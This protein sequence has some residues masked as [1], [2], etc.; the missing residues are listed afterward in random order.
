MSEPVIV[1]PPKT[2]SINRK[3]QRPPVYQQQPRKQ[4]SNV[5]ET[6]NVV[7]PS[8]TSDTPSII[9]NTPDF[10]PGSMVGNHFDTHGFNP[11]S[12]IPELFETNEDDNDESYQIF[13]P[14]PSSSS[15]TYYND[16]ISVPTDF[17][18]LNDFLRF[19]KENRPPPMQIQELLDFIPPDEADYPQIELPNVLTS[20]ISKVYRETKDS[21]IAQNKD[22]QTEISLR[23]KSFKQK[24]PEL[25]DRISLLTDDQKSIVIQN[26]I[27]HYKHICLDSQ[28]TVLNKIY[29]LFQKIQKNCQ[30]IQQLSSQQQKITKFLTKDPK[31]QKA[32][33][34]IDLQNQIEQN[35]QAIELLEHNEAKYKILKIFLSFDVT[36]II[37][38]TATVEIFGK[39]KPFQAMD[40]I[41]VHAKAA[42]IQRQKE[43]QVELR[44]ISQLIPFVIH[45]NNVVSVTFVKYDID[46]RFEV[47][48]KI[49]NSYPWTKMKVSTKT[50][51]GNA[52]DIETR[53][54]EF[55]NSMT[56]CRMPILTLCRSIIDYY[57]I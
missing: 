17:E 41:K 5:F 38:G 37:K 48:F 25:L 54:N 21:L 9:Q 1:L 49:S 47:S 56:Y 28:L 55:L 46:I 43:L 44:L 18:I 27:D 52:Q 33:S 11:T 13:N 4:Q 34:L 23:E 3:P 53:V 24:P 12:P 26:S 50:V 35:K 51:I 42:E 19:E 6:T 45:Q 36:R 31:I 40:A 39:N 29:N 30:N 10:R 20:E 2:R 16:D 7:F 8:P 14:S 57:Q 15:E 22:M 32:N